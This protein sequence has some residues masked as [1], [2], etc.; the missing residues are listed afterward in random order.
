MAQNRAACSFRTSE[1]SSR[2]PQSVVSITMMSDER[3]E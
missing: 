1:T 3:H 2:C